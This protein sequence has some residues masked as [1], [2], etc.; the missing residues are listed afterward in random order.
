MIMWDDRIYL[1]GLPV[2]CIFFSRIAT[3]IHVLIPAIFFR[4]YHSRVPKFV[5]CRPPRYKDSKTEAAVEKR[6]LKFIFWLH[7]F[8]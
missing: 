2:P 6:V 3:Y 8:E 4:F 1:G 7:V 5:S